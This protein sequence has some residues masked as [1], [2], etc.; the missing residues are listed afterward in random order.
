M[1]CAEPLLA[2]RNIDSSVEA[3]CVVNLLLACVEISGVFGWLS[4]APDK[5]TTVR[6][7]DDIRSYRV[8]GVYIRLSEHLAN[9][10]PLFVDLCNVHGNLDLFTSREALVFFSTV[11][12]QKPQGQV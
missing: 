1:T 11:P 9:A 12:P 6:L 4:R 2:E 5:T 10:F 8:R 3:L 7:A